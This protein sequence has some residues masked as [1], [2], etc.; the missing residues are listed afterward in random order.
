MNSAPSSLARL[1]SL[2]LKHSNG[3]LQPIPSPDG[4]AHPP[5]S[6]SRQKTSIP[7]QPDTHHSSSVSEIAPTSNPPLDTIGGEVTT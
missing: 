6:E 4:T 7:N 2:G 3:S 5:D 1:V